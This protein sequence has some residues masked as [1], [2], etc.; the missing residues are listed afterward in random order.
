MP[1]DPGQYLKFAA[2]RERPALD[3]LARIPVG[4]PGRVYDLGCGSG[5]TTRLLRQRWPKARITGVDSSPEMLAEAR[6][7]P[8]ESKAHDPLDYV[9]G[10]LATWLPGDPV[11][12]LYSNAALHWIGG[13][14]T[15]FPKLMR[16]LTPQGVLA[17]QMPT[18][19]DQPRLAVLAELA[20]RPQWRERLVPLLFPRV[21]TSA[22]YYDLLAPEVRALDIWQTDYLHVLSGEDPVAEWSRGS[23]LGPLLAAL[24]PREGE[25]FYG[26]YAARMRA[27]YPK[28]PDGT[29]LLSFP[30]IFIVAQ[31]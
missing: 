28:R 23:S 1:W 6:R 13:H 4:N 10:D 29:T 22:D 17:V 30:R 18:G 15:L 9:Q 16:A 2:P 25:A 19:Q 26:E 7:A 27:A 5:N 20:A 21:G 14:E 31:R 3:L 12:L 11:D 8:A 24:D